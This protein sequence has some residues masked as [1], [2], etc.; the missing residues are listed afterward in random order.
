MPC[1]KQGNTLLVKARSAYVPHVSLMLLVLNHYENQSLSSPRLLWVGRYGKNVTVSR[2]SKNPLYSFGLN[3]F[4][5]VQSKASQQQCLSIFA[6]VQKW[7]SI[8]SGKDLLLCKV[9]LQRGHWLSPHHSWE[10]STM[11]PPGREE[12]L[13]FLPSRPL[14]P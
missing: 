4:A 12:L 8:E 7:F 5:S 10:K 6:V 11:W 2:R 3:I 14:P 13:F 1:R 9:G